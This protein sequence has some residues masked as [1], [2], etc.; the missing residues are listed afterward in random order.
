MV[1]LHH[2]KAMSF[3]QAAHLGNAF[4]LHFTDALFG[5]L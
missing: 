1:R 4:A 5:L 3:I 2:N